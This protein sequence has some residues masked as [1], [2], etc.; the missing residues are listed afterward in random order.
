MSRE[1]TKAVFH[2]VIL[3]ILYWNGTEYT[4]KIALILATQ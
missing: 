1:Y 3:N 4:A 2:N